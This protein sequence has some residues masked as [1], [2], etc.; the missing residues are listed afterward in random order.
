MDTRR[1]QKAL[2]RLFFLS[3]GLPILAVAFTAIWFSDVP[4]VEQ[5]VTNYAFTALLT[6][7]F[8]MFLG[9]IFFRKNIK[10]AYASDD[11]K[12]KLVIFAK[13]FQLKMSFFVI[14]GLVPSF[15]SIMAN[16]YMIVILVIIPVAGIL[17]SRPTLYSISQHI[18]LNEEESEILEKKIKIED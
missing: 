14:A 16:F 9:F 1:Y 17:L 7:L 8:S 15:L 2:Y 3:V 10:K 18:P 4:E 12:E 6:I 5:E 13:S 11:L